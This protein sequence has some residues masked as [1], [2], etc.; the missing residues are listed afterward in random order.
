MLLDDFVDTREELSSKKDEEILALSIKSPSLFGILVDRYEEAFLRKARKIIRREEE[1]EDIVQEAF[2]RIYMNAARFKV[3]EG[4]SF[5]S[6]AYKILINLTLTHYQ[7]L[8]K[9]I[10]ATVEMDPELYEILPDLHVKDSEKETTRDYVASILSRMP[11]NLSK[12]LKLYF[13]DGVPQK[14]IAEAEGVSVGAIKTRIC[15][16]KKDFK[17]I[18]GT[19]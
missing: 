4:A 12:V 7:K 14:E 18:K 2:T 16:A 10:L 13:I 6:W 9:E 15:R 1:A 19:V 3:Q 11:G 8:K 5:K 17:K